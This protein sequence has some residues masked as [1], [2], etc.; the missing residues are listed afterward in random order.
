MAASLARELPHAL[1]M[2]KEQKKKAK[3]KNKKAGSSHRGS[4]ET[5]LTS[6]HEDMGSIPGLTEW[7][8]D[9]AV[10]ESCGVRHRCSSDPGAAVAVV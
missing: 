2:T 7:V 1:G 9:P 6:I 5:R 10:A 3:P 4:V 8:K